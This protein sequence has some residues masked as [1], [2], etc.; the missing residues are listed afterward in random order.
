MHLPCVHGDASHPDAEPRGCPAGSTGPEWGRAASHPHTQFSRLGSLGHSPPPSPWLSQ[1]QRVCTN[2]IL[3]S[4]STGKNEV[5][6]QLHT[7]KAST[8]CHEQSH[9]Q[10]VPGEII[11]INQKLIYNFNS[12]TSLKQCTHMHCDS[13]KERYEGELLTCAFSKMQNAVWATPL[14]LHGLSFM[15]CLC[16]SSTWDFLVSTSGRFHKPL[17]NTHCVSGPGEWETRCVNVLPGCAVQ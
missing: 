8:V 13:P 15:P 16:W 4:C 17:W 9:Q 7:G 5:L 2:H 14:C 6:G 1:E 3:C 10:N 11:R 12:R